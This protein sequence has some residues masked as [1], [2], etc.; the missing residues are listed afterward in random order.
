[1]STGV[2]AWPTPVDYH[3]ALQHPQLCFADPELRAGEVVRTPLG[4]PLV[5]SGNFAS[6]YQV[7]TGPNRDARWAVRC[8][9]RHVADLPRRYAAIDRHLRRRR[10]PSI[11]GFEFVERGVLVRGQWYPIVKMAWVAGQPL[12]AWVEAHLQQPERLRDLATRWTALSSELAAA[13]IA[14]GDLQHGNVLVDGDT[15]QLVDYDGMFVPALGG[16]PGSEVG[17]PAYQHPGRTPR[18]FGPDIDRF[19]ALVVLVALLALALEPAL[20]QRHNNGDNLLFRPAD[21]REPARSAL[22]AELEALGDPGLADLLSVLRRGCAD[23]AAVPPIDRLWPPR[24]APRLSVR[25]AAVTEWWREHLPTPENGHAGEPKS[26]AGGR[27]WW[28]LFVRPERDGARPRGT[29]GG[30]NGGGTPSAWPAW[31]RLMGPVGQLLPARSPAPAPKPGKRSATGARGTS[32]A[33]AAP[34]T[35]P[36]VASQTGRSMHRPDCALVARIEPAKLVAFPSRADALRAG[37]E[38][39]GRCHP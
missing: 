23:G 9:L 5:A 17:H 3:A 31:L 22:F 35:G 27:P 16:L 8:F 12:N 18:D 19:P 11:V 6:V 10:P 13:G 7:R 21:F 26:A 33:R 32:A 20:W 34:T 14:H 37:Y 39:C 28:L 29:N 30:A 25:A 24:F 36:V 4:L 38:P 15:L 2:G 1:M